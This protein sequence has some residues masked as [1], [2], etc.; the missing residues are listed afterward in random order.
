MP[1]TYRH[2]FFCVSCFCFV[3]LASHVVWLFCGTWAFAELCSIPTLLRSPRADRGDSYFYRCAHSHCGH[4]TSILHGSSW[5][6][7]RLSPLVLAKSLDFVCRQKWLTAVSATDLVAN[8]QDVGH[9]KARH[10]LAALRM[11]ECQAAKLRQESLLLQGDLEADA[12]GL[13]S[14]VVKHTNRNFAD[15]IAKHKAKHGHQDVYRVWVRLLGVCERSSSTLIISPLPGKVASMQS[16]P[17]PESL[18]EI[19]FSGLLSR[20]ARG[21]AVH[22]DGAHAWPLS[23]RGMPLHHSNVHHNF[24]QFTGPS[25]LPRQFSKLSGTQCVDRRWKSL[26]LNYMPAELAARE[27]DDSGVSAVNE[28]LWTYCWSFALRQ[29]MSPHDK[30]DLWRA[31]GK[32]CADIRM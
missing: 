28:R 12:T 1:R 6:G 17:P 21:A 3:S 20:L 25:G 26:C 29:N 16:K 18:E 27:R 5:E 11:A 30:A 9:T 2:V 8:V 4:R 7:M 13:R 14:F 10:I 15:Q 23:V 22:S 24:H 19:E 31:L 32:A